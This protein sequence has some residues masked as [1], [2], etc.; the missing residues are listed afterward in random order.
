M[1]HIPQ[2]AYPRVP[3]LR[4]GH[5]YLQRVHL[6]GSSLIS[7]YVYCNALVVHNRIKICTVCTVESISPI[8]FFLSGSEGVSL[9]L[10]HMFEQHQASNSVEELVKG[11]SNGD[12]VRVEQLLDAEAC[13]VDDQF[14]GKTALHTAAQN[15]HVDVIRTLI[16]HRANLEE[17]VG[18]L[19]LELMVARARAEQHA[20]IIENFG[21][22]MD[23][24]SL[25]CPLLQNHTTTNVFVTRKTSDCLSYS[26]L[27]YGW[28]LFRE[29]VTD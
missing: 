26:I 19:Y 25:P 6:L 28:A 4:V 10:R 18:G 17:E 9:L 2:S 7:L 21:T 24:F 22:C 23:K 29:Y 27:R 16:R 3:F 20:S 14:N 8:V 11:A 13:G 5:T 15:G 12:M 1:W